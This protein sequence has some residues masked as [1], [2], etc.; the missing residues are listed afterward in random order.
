MRDTVTKSRDRSNPITL[1]APITFLYIGTPKNGSP[2]N[3]GEPAYFFGVSPTFPGV[4]HLFPVSCFSSHFLGVILPTPLFLQVLLFL[5]VFRHSA[6]AR[7]GSFLWHS[8]KYWRRSPI[9]RQACSFPTISHRAPSFS[10][11]VKKLLT[12]LEF[13]VHFSQ[14][15]LVHSP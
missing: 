14:I 10:G 12:A 1:P 15:T 13:F 9:P 3:I 2:R 5:P 8:K 7:F 4:L 11:G 6:Q